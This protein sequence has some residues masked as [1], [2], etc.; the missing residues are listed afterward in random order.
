MSMLMAGRPQAREDDK[1]INSPRRALHVVIALGWP[2]GVAR[3]VP[4]VPQGADH[5][6][7]GGQI[8][9][10]DAL[11]LVHQRV[12]LAAVQRRAELL[13]QVVHL[14][15]LVALEI[16]AAGGRHADRL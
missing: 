16:V 6:G 3:G 15:V 1:T 9:R 2:T 8:L 14:W 11:H 5:H 10:P 4:L 13:E 7:D 12:L